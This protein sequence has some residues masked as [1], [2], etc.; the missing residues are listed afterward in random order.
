MIAVCVRHALRVV[1]GVGLVLMVAGLTLLI[2]Y[3][4]F[5]STWEVL[6]VSSPPVAAEPGDVPAEDVQGWSEGVLVPSAV[7]ERRWRSGLA[8]GR[9]LLLA[10]T[11]VSCVGGGGLLAM[12]WR[13]HLTR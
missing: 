4:S 8:S 11:L 13:R 2:H 5:F 3:E 6:H 1:L 7:L 12:G 9:R 10:G